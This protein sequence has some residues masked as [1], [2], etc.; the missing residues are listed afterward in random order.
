[1]EIHGYTASGN[2][3]ATIE[4]ARRIVPDDPAN[5]HRQMIAEWEAEGNSIPPYVPPPEPTP[6]L[7]KRQVTAA[8]IV[9][10]N[11]LDPEGAITA[12]IEAMTDPVQRALALNDWRNAPYYRRDHA[13]FNDAN[14]LT[15]M[16]LTPTQ[17]DQLWTLAA[18]LPA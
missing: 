16:N 17:V 14:L 18:S 7:T 15:A 13:L 5:R 11:Q 2:I 8:L 1:M 6:T 3:D 9:G 10:A 12:A 4:G